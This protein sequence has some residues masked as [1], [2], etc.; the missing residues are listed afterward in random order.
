MSAFAGKLLNLLLYQLG[1]FCC[2][3]GASWGS[4]VVGA[5]AASS[6]VAIHLLLARARKSELLLIFAAGLLGLVVDSLLQGLGGLTFKA[7]S[8]WPFWLPLWVP[9][10]WA[11]FATLFHY[12]LYWLSGRYLLAALLGAL[13]GPLAYWGGINLGAAEIS[14]KPTLSLFLLA[15]TWAVVM[16]VLLWLSDQTADGEGRYRWPAKN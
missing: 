1:W 4:P 5:V 10:I 16:P 3:L 11:Q 13:G 8:G 7:D 15:V 12:A 9:V 14:G 2:V 6:L